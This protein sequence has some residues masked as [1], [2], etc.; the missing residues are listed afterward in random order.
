LKSANLKHKSNLGMSEFSRSLCIFK[1]TVKPVYVAYPWFWS[2]FPTYT[3]GQ[4]LEYDP[5]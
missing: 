3:G 2:N 4:F 5:K 1:I